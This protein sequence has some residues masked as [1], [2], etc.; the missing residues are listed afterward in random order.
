MQSSTAPATIATSRRGTGAT[1]SCSHPTSPTTIPAR[2]SAIAKA[3]PQAP[4]G[5]GGRQQDSHARLSIARGQP[6]SSVGVRGGDGTIA[7]ESRTSTA[8]AA[9]ATGGDSSTSASTSD[10]H[11]ETSMEARVDADIER[12]STG[13]PQEWNGNEVAEANTQAPDIIQQFVPTPPDAEEDGLLCKQIKS[14]STK[15]GRRSTDNTRPERHPNKRYG[16]YVP[17]TPRTCTYTYAFIRTETH[18]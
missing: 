9:A 17:A 2:M 18:T 13:A 10:R 1:P 15:R 3:M 11:Q 7:A 8:P 12:G 6:R 5:T 14:P 4:S 16:R